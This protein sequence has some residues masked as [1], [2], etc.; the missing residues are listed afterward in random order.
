MGCVL[1]T[2]WVGISARMGIGRYCSSIVERLMKM[3]KGERG[4]PLTDKKYATVN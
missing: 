2:C 4:L 1:L 3:N